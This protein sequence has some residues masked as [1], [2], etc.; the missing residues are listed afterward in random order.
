MTK[1]KFDIQD[2]F[3][4]V[5][6]KEKKKEASEELIWHGLDGFTYSLPRNLHVDLEKLAGT[7][8]HGVWVDEPISTECEH[9][10]IDVG[11]VKPK[12]VCKKCDKDLDI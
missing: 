2:C 4:G 3:K 6:H 9:E 12:M 1:P 10:P 8:I 7:S 11:F 5:F